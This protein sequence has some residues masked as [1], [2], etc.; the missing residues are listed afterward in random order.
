MDEEPDIRYRVDELLP[1]GL[2]TIHTPGRST[3][4]TRSGG[5]RLRP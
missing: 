1:G 4:I 2:K 3:R 5:N